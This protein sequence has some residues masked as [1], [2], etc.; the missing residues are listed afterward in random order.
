M[1]DRFDP[2][3]NLG[4]FVRG[5]YPCQVIQYLWPIPPEFERLSI[6]FDRQFGLALLVL[7]QCQIH[8]LMGSRIGMAGI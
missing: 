1:A 3:T 4:V 5:Q 2:I 7:Q 8:V 6:P